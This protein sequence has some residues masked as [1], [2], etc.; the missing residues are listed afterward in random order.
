M[1]P[2]DQ[3]HIQ[4][5]S[6]GI[7]I[8]KIKG[9]AV[10]R[11]LGP[12][13]KWCL[14][15]LAIRPDYRSIARLKHEWN[16]LKE[17]HGSPG[18]TKN[19]TWGNSTFGPSIS[20]ESTQE[21]FRERFIVPGYHWDWKYFIFCAKA[22]VQAIHQVH[23]RNICHRLIRPDVFYINQNEITLRD[24]FESSKLEMDEP[25]SDILD[26][27]L[28]YLAPEST[29]RTGRIG[30]DMRADFYS[31]GASF[32]ELITGKL[33]FAAQD[34]LGLVHAHV[35][36]PVIPLYEID[37]SVPRMISDIVVKL[38]QKQPEDRY[39][40]L[41]GLIYDLEEINNRLLDGRPS[42]GF[43]AGRLDLA[44]RFILSQRLH[45][46]E[47]E[48][49]IIR[50]AFD[51]VQQSGKSELA[52]VTGFSGVGKSRL[53]KELYEQLTMARAFFVS[54]K[55]EQNKRNVPFSALIQA[56]SSLTKQL[57]TETEDSLQKWRLKIEQA[58]GEEIRVLAEVVPDLNKLL[59]ESQHYPPLPELA[60]LASEERF[61][62]NLKKFLELFA[63]PGRP[64]IMFID[65]LQWAGHADIRAFI[66]TVDRSGKDAAENLLFLCA[67]R[68][69]EMTADQLAILSTQLENATVNIHLGPL[70][71]KQVQDIVCETL[72]R[73]DI[74]S[75]DIAELCRHMMLRT[76]GNAFFVTQLLKT[77][78]VKECIVFDYSLAQWV[79]D[80]PATEKLEI[81][82]DILTLVL[83]QLHQLVGE[84]TRRTL[85]TA[86]ALGNSEFRLDTMALVLQSTPYEIAHW[87]F[88]AL[89]SGFILP[90]S[91][92][93]RIPLAMDEDTAEYASVANPSGTFSQTTYHAMMKDISKEVTYRFLHD[94]VQ[95]SAYNLYSQSKMMVLH[96]NI[97]RIFLQNYDSQAIQDNI[98]EV[99]QQL[100][101]GIS[102]V[103]DPSEQYL[104]AE[105]N[106]DAASKALQQTAF[107]V[108]R[109]HLD[110]AISLINR[111]SPLWLRC[112]ELKFAAD[113]SLCDYSAALQAADDYLSA[114]TTRTQ[115]VFI[116]ERKCKALM[117]SG[118]IDQA[119]NLGIE[120]L[121]WL[122]FEF[123][124]LNNTEGLAEM[125]SKLWDMIPVNISAISDV[126][127]LP[128]LTDT[129]LLQVTKLMVTLIPPLFLISIQHSL[130]I[131]LLAATQAIEHGNSGYS[132][133][134][135][136]FIAL[137]FSDVDAP[138]C[139]FAAGGRWCDVSENVVERL[140]TVQLKAA[141]YT[142][143]GCVRSWT[144]HMRL[145]RGPFELAIKNAETAWDGEYIAF[146]GLDLL[147][148]S[149]F[150]GEPLDKV[151]EVGA[152]LEPV[153]RTFNRD[154]GT[155]YFTPFF[156]GLCNL[157]GQGRSKD[158]CI[159]EGPIFHELED[160][161]RLTGMGLHLCYYYLIKCK[162]SIL[163][164]RKDL[165]LEI[166]NLGEKVIPEA[167]GMLAQPMFAFYST[168]AY[169]D[170]ID[171][172]NEE[173]M[174]IITRN[175]DRMQKWADACPENFK[176]LY[177]I[178][179]AEVAKQENTILEAV[180]LYD[181]AIAYAAEQQR[182]QVV[183][184]ANERAGE[185]L[186]ATMGK[187]M[188]LGYFSDAYQN[189]LKQ[190][191]T[192]TGLFDAHLLNSPD[193]Y[194]F[195]IPFGKNRQ[196]AADMPDMKTLQISD[197]VAPMTNPEDGFETSR[198]PTPR[199]EHPPLQPGNQ[200]DWMSVMKATLTISSE[201]EY[202]ALVKRIMQI[203]LAAAGADYCALAVCKDNVLRV[204]ATGTIDSMTLHPSLP[205][206]ECADLLPL[207]VI[208]YVLHSDRQIVD[209]KQFEKDVPVTDEYL[210]KH[211]PKS[212]L[213]VPLK[214]QSSLVAVIYLQNNHISQVFTKHRTE[215]IQLLLSQAA[216]SIQKAEYGQQLET[217]A[218][219]L[220]QMVEN[221]TRELTSKNAT[222]H[223]QIRERQ[224][225]EIELKAAKETAENAT[226]MKSNF[227]AMMSH[228]IRTPCNGIYGC[229]TLLLDSQLNHQQSEY[230][231]TIRESSAS[232]LH[233]I[234]DILDLARIENNSI[235]LESA[236][237]SIRSCIE[238]TLSM[239]GP[240]AYS[241]NLE[242]AYISGIDEALDGI[243]GDLTRVRQCVLNLVYNAL[244]FTASGEIRVTS[245]CQTVSQTSS[246]EKVIDVIINVIDTGMGIPPEKEDRLFKLFSQ[247]DTSS[248]RV[249][250]GS[251]LGLVTSRRLAQ[252]MGGDLHFQ[253][254]NSGDITMDGA[255]ENDQTGSNFL[256]SFKAT[257]DP[258]VNLSVTMPTHDLKARVCVVCDT[259]LLMQASLSQIL[260]SFG[261]EVII[262]DT[263]AE[264][265][266]F[267]LDKLEFAFIGNIGESDRAHIIDALKKYS[268]IRA[269]ILVTAPGDTFSDTLGNTQADSVLMKPIK[270][271]RLYDENSR[272][273][274]KFRYH[275]IRQFLPLEGYTLENP[276]DAANILEPEP[277][278][279]TGSRKLSILL[280]E[281]NKVN[282]MV[283]IKLLKREGFDE[284]DVAH[285]GAEA[286][287]ASGV[288]CYDLILMDIN[289]PRMDGLQATSLIRQT[290]SPQGS[291]HIVALTANA[292][293]GDR[294]RC[295]T[296]GC[297]D[298]LTKPVKLNELQRILK[299]C[300]SDAF[301]KRKTTGRLYSI[302]RKSSDIS[303]GR[304]GGWIIKTQ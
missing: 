254:R 35:A 36:Q 201:T 43:Q 140:G 184:L 57:Y 232:L 48:V 108:A 208:R 65:D 20:V 59:G 176:P 38:L 53:I 221:G 85:V 189:Y 81:A 275:V 226:R 304:T 92:N 26:G 66:G 191:H 103:T 71:Y 293:S 101:R 194:S 255:A 33:P 90:G 75:P 50:D 182:H 150:G 157:R 111:V 133:Y 155:F 211:N 170:N 196:S 294:D 60:P 95:E 256:F 257:V 137:W 21:T 164:G 67:Y 216:I 227:L 130:V 181:E 9:I 87:L 147:M 121:H 231:S 175:I 55:F 134:V 163:F 296:A 27:Q 54:G 277:M 228:E 284:V 204:E 28:P 74:E 187:K 282:V 144:R 14:L 246:G 252:L 303:D 91:S 171:S 149:E 198:P 292:M 302:K 287:E 168:L 128:D 288:K 233:I 200:L 138:R 238:G 151:W 63:D 51:R 289:M 235:E 209:L 11:A 45:G 49:K 249:F 18:V 131:C 159:L 241:K 213:A 225:V 220:K 212:M 245:S 104:I 127:K 161:D 109:D 195:I 98:F 8:W 13:H 44:S 210:S 78:Y 202:P 136:A 148:W 117:A 1:K 24:F 247:V 58:L 269:I 6:Q 142:I 283:A 214:N 178:M 190:D 129:F 167:A 160:R 5:Y 173:Q 64:L 41:E 297:N 12:E 271:N 16:I 145:S 141:S 32:Y 89:L 17:L 83:S 174:A 72:C 166:T 135:Y 222:L 298:Y 107:C 77:L 29:G 62:R 263:F 258:N 122:G 177:L 123:P 179:K 125:E 188:A 106:I 223:A 76:R 215:I 199:F 69:H 234:N 96:L 105:L 99:C 278:E 250:G 272:Y 70:K 280:V 153:I 93:Y 203:L 94:R 295:L 19:A 219:S 224:R 262:C 264:L 15:K 68:D 40:T 183:A 30:S 244:K 261:L 279:M 42:E 270:K 242:I 285:D 34:Q 97:G 236:P 3:V 100:N 115:K 192:A 290:Q 112:L 267:V 84:N 47:G 218:H 156:Q 126:E 80:M 61:K 7:L 281:D 102:L 152:K 300:M 86:A 299:F 291:P 110:V 180:K 240:E 268:Q 139:N 118:S 251:G 185:M 132:A 10:V 243:I 39:S 46:R 162:L 146:A 301:R 165:A 25:I 154:V 217:Y 229:T 239:I 207:K 265:N 124:R 186:S 116:T 79:W 274:L 237:F 205:L 266:R 113:F 172:L 88:P 193:P 253:P 52:F 22:I 120:C 73:T 37:S 248:T 4:G 158:I 82:D 143:I 286:V 2:G 276:K 197:W 230:V 23:A 273:Q 206:D 169:F 259:S 31:L 56:L 119:L 114:S 260:G